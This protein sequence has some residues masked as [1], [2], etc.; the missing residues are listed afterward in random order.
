MRARGR[1]AF[2]LLAHLMGLFI[3]YRLGADALDEYACKSGDA[4]ALG[5]AARAAPNAGVYLGLAAVNG[6]S[7]TSPDM[8]KAINYCRKAIRAAP[9]YD[10]PWYQL[11]FACQSAG[12]R[13]QAEAALDRY[14][15]LGRFCSSDMWNAGVFRLVAWADA[16]GAAAYFRRSIELAPASVARAGAIY[17][18]MGASQDY[19]VKHLLP[20]SKDVYSRYMRYLVRRGG[21]E[22]ALSFWRLGR[23]FIGSGEA[24]S[25]CELLISRGL[26]DEAWDE[27]RQCSGNR[28]QRSWRDAT[29]VDGGFEGQ[30]NQKSCF[31]WVAEK[32]PGVDILPGRRNDGADRGLLVRFDGQEA[33]GLQIW[34][35]VRVTPGRSYELSA[36]IKTENIITASG[37]FLAVGNPRCGFY[38]QSGQVK[39]TGKW[40]SV[41]IDFRA[42]PGCPLLMAAIARK[43]ALK[44]DPK[45]DSAAWVDDVRMTALKDRNVAGR[46][47]TV[48]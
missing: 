20:P 40:R 39:G 36:E 22:E 17:L 3:I 38:A 15:A 16:D 43:N 44:L 9:L 13:R 33:P 4:E 14:A 25:L 12:D 32:R 8:S 1:R 42:P 37:V 26:Y 31:G 5:L 29:I 28:A 34:Q 23:G 47:R 11:A 6:Y 21:A 35:F 41:S 7:L 46:G 27:W 19:I 2:L 48:P 45:E 10:A 30:V 18:S 24:A